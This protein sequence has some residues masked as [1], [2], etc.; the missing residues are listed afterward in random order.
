MNRPYQLYG[1]LDRVIFT[2][3]AT[4]RVVQE[5]ITKLKSFILIAF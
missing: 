4:G 2:R 5:S 1:S 3:G